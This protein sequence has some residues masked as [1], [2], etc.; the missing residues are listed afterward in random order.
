MIDFAVNDQREV[1]GSLDWLHPSERQLCDAFKFKK[2]K[3]DWLLGRWTAKNLVQKNWFKQ[4]DLS[5]IAILPGENRAPFLYLGEQTT[6]QQI[7]ISHSQGIAL[8]ATNDSGSY[9]GCDLE[10]IEKRSKHF[11]EA[12]PLA[13]LEFVKK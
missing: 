12:L 8:C 2:R 5:E 11:Y 6:F 10:R 7:S 3:N 9:L 4:Y 13:G 1:P